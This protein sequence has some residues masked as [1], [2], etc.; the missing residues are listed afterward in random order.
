MHELRSILGKKTIVRR[1]QGGGGA[2]VIFYLFFS[3]K[4]YDSK[5]IFTKHVLKGRVSSYVNE[6]FNYCDFLNLR[7]LKRL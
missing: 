7:A 2:L 1:M 5:Q 3:I 6:M 4:S